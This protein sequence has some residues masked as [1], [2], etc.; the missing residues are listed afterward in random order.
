MLQT[1][2]SLCVSFFVL[3]FVCCLLLWLVVSSCCLM[4]FIWCYL[5]GALCFMFF[6]QRYC[7]FCYYLLNVVTVFVIFCSMLL[8]WC[9][10]SLFNVAIVLVIFCSMLLA[11]CCC[12]FCCFL[13]NT[14]VFLVTPCSMLLLFLLFLVWCC[15]SFCCEVVAPLFFTFCLMLLPPLL[16]FW[17]DISPLIFCRCGRSYPNSSFL[18]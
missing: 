17:I 13:L 1:F 4:L 7:C 11:Q 18:G 10:C 9:C 3:F 14:I 15:Y 8:T 6:T 12:S 2:F 16:V 5:F